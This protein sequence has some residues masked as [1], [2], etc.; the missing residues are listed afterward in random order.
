MAI[1]RQVIDDAHRFRRILQPALDVIEAQDAPDLGDVEGA[2]MEGD[3]VRRLQVPGDDVHAAAAGGYRID[4]VADAADEK[5]AALA[6][7]E[8]ART[9]HVVRVHADAKAGRQPDLVDA[10]CCCS[11][12]TEES[13]GDESEGAHGASISGFAS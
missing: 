10:G 1:A 4:T 6:E 13:C 12:R 5:R 8:R 9:A 11:G 3:A 2:G 7:R